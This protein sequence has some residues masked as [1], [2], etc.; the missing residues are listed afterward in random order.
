MFIYLIFE[1]SA[2]LVS[3]W[4]IVFRF[5]NL[6]APQL[7]LH[8][9][10]YAGHFPLAFSTLISSCLLL[11]CLFSLLFAFA[12]LVVYSLF[13]MGKLITTVSPLH[14]LYICR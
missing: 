2:F 14:M 9:A 1:S 4:Y 10:Q 7:L 5:T 12:Q 13:S 3:V 6:S 11:H 8:M